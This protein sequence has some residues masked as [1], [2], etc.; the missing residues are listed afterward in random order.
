MT[1][2]TLM[3]MMNGQKFY[4]L[5]RYHHHS[6]KNISSSIE[7]FIY[8][9]NN[10]NN[11]A[12]RKL[13][14]QQQQ[15]Q[16]QMKNKS[17]NHHY[18]KH[19]HRHRLQRKFMKFL[20]Q[21]NLILMKNN[22][23]KHLKSLDNKTM[24]S[25]WRN[26]SSHYYSQNPMLPFFENYSYGV[27]PM[28]DESIS[29]I[30]QNQFN[31]HKRRKNNSSPTKKPNIIFILTDD[32]DIE[33]GSMN[34]MPK[35][36]KIM[37]NQGVH[38]KNAYS[39]T[40]MCCP[41][42]S[43]ILT[44]LYVHNH[45]VY[46]NGENCSSTQWQQTHERQTFATYL[47]DFG[48]Y[49]TAYFGKYL[50]EYNGSY[51]PPG[52]SDWSALIRNS[53]YYNYTLNVNGDKIRHGFDYHLDYYPDLI[54]NDSLQFIRYS[55][56]FFNSKPYLMVLSFPSPH[57]PEDSAPQ[58]QNL[59]MNEKSHR[60]M[61]W[62]YAPN[63]D[64]QWLLRNTDKMSHI[65]QEFTDF[66]NAKRLQTL[67]SVD[68]AVNQ[69]FQELK[70]LNELD[71]TYIIYT[72]DHGYHLGQFGLVKG[73]A[74]PF[75]F[76]IRV[77]FFIRGPNVPS[78]KI[79]QQIVLNIDIAPT[80]LDIAGIRIPEHM[81]GISFLPYIRL[82]MN[83]NSSEK[84]FERLKLMKRDTFLV[85]RGKFQ[86]FNSHNKHNNIDRLLIPIV[87]KKQWLQFQCL[88]S[89]YQSPCRA[90]QRFECF[91]NIN[92][93]QRIRKCPSINRKNFI[94][95]QKNS[96]G[97]CI[98]PPLS[99]TSVLKRNI[100]SI[101]T[102]KMDYH[103]RRLK[104]MRRKQQQ[105]REMRSKNFSN[106]ARR[107]DKFVLRLPDN[108]LSIDID[109]DV[110]G[111]YEMKKLIEISK[112]SSLSIE[113]NNNNSNHDNRLLSPNNNNNLANITTSQLVSILDNNNPDDYDTFAD[114]A[115]YTDYLNR[116]F[117]TVT[118]SNFSIE[119]SEEIYSN[120]QVWREKKDYIN[121]AIIEL[122]RRLSELKG[123]RRY[124]NENR[125]SSSSSSSLSSSSNPLVLGK[126]SNPKILNE[127]NEC[128]CP[129]S[130]A[131]TTIIQDNDDDDSDNYNNN[132]NENS[133]DNYYDDHHNKEMNNDNNNKEN[134]SDLYHDGMGR[135]R[136]IRP[137][138][139]MMVE[140]KIIFIDDDDDDVGNNHNNNYAGHHHHHHRHRT[141]FNLKR[142]L[143]RREKKIRRQDKFAKTECKMAANG[144]M[145]CFTHD[146]D[147]W[148]TPP[149]WTN[150]PFCFC[151]NSLNSS[152]WCMRTINETH[153]NLYCEFVT[154]F[155][156]YYDL[157][158]DPFQ[159]RNLIFDLDFNVVEEMSRQLARLKS[160]S[161][162]FD[163]STTNNAVSSTIVDNI[164]S[165]TNLI[166][167][168][169]TLK[170]LPFRT[171]SQR[172]ISSS[173][174]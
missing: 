33:L 138:S 141:P 13:R 63:G 131:T 115:N 43:S 9:N 69:I 65:H 166:S 133:E 21:Q 117:C 7:P 158:K 85:E 17:K 47:R 94:R 24:K 137:S 37:A 148:K 119:C 25:M 128:F 52:W 146:N 26:F 27:Q 8:N 81:D 161:G 156:T 97:E 60:T 143:R 160:C 93:V 104:K 58:Y 163:C 78:G 165:S 172:L 153:N 49:R 123:I 3:M 99:T 39:T 173:I 29:S 135:R 168:K 12:K 89:E 11:V 130:I 150:G 83:E 125:P 74:M 19:K 72:S 56:R 154:G 114:L 86:T 96:Q 113:S 1:V 23:D 40:P 169:K 67:Q 174:R 105:K 102:L 71:N 35:T 88:K 18:R 73:K 38:V 116:T 92:G 112:S 80:L 46:T 6:S 159:L 90:N 132:N 62:N 144:H 98:C 76:D 51:I 151:Q 10:N 84:N 95:S 134:V 91:V 22:G 136:L 53:R 14:K 106:R 162:A 82:L 54:L 70:N 127:E 87:G 101:R 42:R 30:D 103:H 121:A 140:S 61:S 122:Q 149:L 110:Q 36:M 31:H 15:Q 145:N 59:F 64:K 124:I 57:G 28:I 109:F 139:S 118:R 34:Y 68:E 167:K 41:S 55:K 2:L 100:D 129:K 79:L 45:N 170:S 32:Q 142:W 171:S 50:N 20:R 157:D 111:V 108:R 107:S 126:K 120:H 164:Q 4:T 48:G 44:G 147:H 155:I 5:H 75:E 16:Q 66:L 77:P 152:F